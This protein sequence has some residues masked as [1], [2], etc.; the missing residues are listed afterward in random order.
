MA[1]IQ[2]LQRKLKTQIHIKKG[3]TIISSQIDRKITKR[4]RG[5]M[6]TLKVGMLQEIQNWGLINSNSKQ[7]TSTCGALD[8]SRK[9]LWVSQAKE[10]LIDKQTKEIPLSLWQLGD[11]KFLFGFDWILGFP[12]AFEL[13]R[14]LQAI[15]ED[16]DVSRLLLFHAERERERERERDLSSSSSSIQIQTQS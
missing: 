2:E 14:E 12:F 8:L 1:Y 16:R 7:F 9:G 5:I 13:K 3:T 4:Y 15:K 6:K 10:T 11:Q